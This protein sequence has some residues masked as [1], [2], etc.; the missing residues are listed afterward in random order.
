MSQA[1]GLIVV[2]GA[3][4]SRAGLR[5]QGGALALL[6]PTGRL[7]GERGCG[8]T[9][10]AILGKLGPFAA[11]ARIGGKLSLI[12]KLNDDGSFEG[13]DDAEDRAAFAAILLETRQIQAND[14]GVG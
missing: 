5:Q 12:D 10:F 2:A 14:L 8:G 6:G 7:T 4:G 9:L 13:I 11:H 1:G 3:T